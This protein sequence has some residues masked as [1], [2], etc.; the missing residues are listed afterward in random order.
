MAQYVASLLV[1]AALPS[2]LIL[3]GHGPPIG[4]PAHRLRFYL[5]HRAQREG[6]VLSA[7]ARGPL[8]LEE[9]VPL[10]YDDTPGANPAL[11]ARSA[12]AHLLKLRGEG[13]AE[14]SP[15]GVWRRVDP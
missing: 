7:L 14:V 8:A 4:G 13:R 5:E 12:L 10:A 1:L 9:L 2:T 6:K 3:P 11:A 15:D